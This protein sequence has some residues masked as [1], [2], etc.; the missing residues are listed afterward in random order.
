MEHPLVFDGHSSTTP[1][2]YDSSKLNPSDPD[3]STVPDSSLLP[4]PTDEQWD[5]LFLQRL[6]QLAPTLHAAPPPPPNAC[7][8]NPP[9]FVCGPLPA[10]PGQ[11]VTCVPRIDHSDLNQLAARVLPLTAS[12]G[13]GDL[14]DPSTPDPRFS[15]FPNQFPSAFS[16]CCGSGQL[17]LPTSTKPLQCFTLPQL[18]DRLMP[19]EK[20]NIIH[21]KEL[22][23]RTNPR[24]LAQLK[25]TH[26]ELNAK[27]KNQQPIANAREALWLNE[28]RRL[29]SLYSLDPSL[30]LVT[31]IR[32][33]YR[34]FI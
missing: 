13:H 16:R 15:L 3:P 10:L 2:F 21:A 8:M 6:I 25:L 11:V 31:L 23:F 22:G 29:L 4:E 19:N 26:D 28:S 20:Q 24:Q 1:C 14:D 34:E 30:I 27:Y 17:S 5:N 12:R 33:N 18:K 32:G 7:K 9:G